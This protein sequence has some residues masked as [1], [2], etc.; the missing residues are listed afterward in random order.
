M[1]KLKLHWL[2]ENDVF[3]SS[4]WFVS[5]WET[6]KIKAGTIFLLIYMFL[7][8]LSE[9]PAAA[10]LSL[11]LYRSISRQQFKGLTL[12]ISMDNSNN[13]NSTDKKS[14][15]AM[16]FCVF[17][18]WTERKRKIEKCKK[19]HTAGRCRQHG[20]LGFIS[21]HTKYKKHAKYASSYK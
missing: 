9:R 1:I 18:L 14:E 4:R 13:L 10:I 2:V 17:P 3:K 21:K 12:N 6:C 11:T 16:W 5:K 7:S 15:K 20:L 8:R 19:P